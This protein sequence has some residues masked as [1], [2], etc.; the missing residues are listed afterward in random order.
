MNLKEAIK[1]GQLSDFVDQAEAEGVGP[2]DRKQFES[3][4]D[5]TV[6]P[7]ED[8]TSRSPDR[9]GSPEK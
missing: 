4:M 8:Q 1:E 5:V 3:L 7:Q 6:R 2:A 9:D